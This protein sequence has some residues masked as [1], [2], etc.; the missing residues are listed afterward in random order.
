MGKELELTF[1]Q[2]RYLN[3]R[4]VHENMIIVTKLGDIREMQINANQ[5]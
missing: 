2:R 3:D 4:L 5:N 1:L